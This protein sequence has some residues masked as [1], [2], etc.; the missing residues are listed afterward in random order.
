MSE[1]E[2]KVMHKVSPDKTRCT[3]GGDFWGKDVCQYHTH[4]D[5]TH[6]RKAPKEK[7][8][9]KCTLFDKWLPGE[10]IKCEECRR[11][12]Q[13]AEGAV[14]AVNVEKKLNLGIMSTIKEGMRK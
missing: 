2:I 11:A 7:A 4:R 3:Y 13:E 1:I 14:T 10:C 6:G 5:R 12:C 8:L 9:P